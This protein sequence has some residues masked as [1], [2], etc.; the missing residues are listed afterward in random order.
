M[1]IKSNQTIKEFGVALRVSIGPVQHNY[2]LSQDAMRILLMG[3]VLT[4]VWASSIAMPVTQKDVIDEPMAM[5][6]N[7]ENDAAKAFLSGI[8]F[9][10]S[11]YKEMHPEDN[12]VTA[13]ASDA[14]RYKPIFKY[15]GEA[16]KNCFPDWA[17]SSNNGQ[18]RDTLNTNAPVYYQTTSCSGTMVYT[19]WHW[20]GWQ[21]NCDCCNGAHDDD[22]EHI[23]VYV[24]NN[25]AN[26]VVFHQHAGH[27]TRR[28]GEFERSGERPIVYVGKNAHG[29]YH[30]GC[31]GREWWNPGKVTYC[32]GGC[33]YW[34]D[35]RN[36]GPTWSTGVLTD[37][38]P[39]QTIDGIE[40]PNRPICTSDIGTCEGASVR[41]MWTS[42]CWQNKP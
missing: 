4:V 14:E 42:G 23:S 39:G 38:K 28:R 9:G 37:L 15:D 11:K 7:T 35:Y 22:W 33:G 1:E 40:R 34:N 31:N 24:Q 17:T 6:F 36:P 12:R 30:I 5:Q 2:L 10:F 18:C 32:P 19:Y 8:Y 27:Y 20:Y 21:N 3:L 13:A 25:Q 29:S 41:V 26:K 16:Y